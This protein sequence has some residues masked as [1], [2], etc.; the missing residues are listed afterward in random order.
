MAVQIAFKDSADVGFWKKKKVDKIVVGEY[1]H[2]HEEADRY[3][4][5]QLENER[6]TVIEVSLGKSNSSIGGIIIAGWGF[7]SGSTRPRATDE[8]TVNVPIRAVMHLY[9]QSVKTGKIM[10]LTNPDKVKAD[11]TGKKGDFESFDHS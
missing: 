6:S 4:V 3:S 2:M 1:M 5:G 9:N 11:F 10:D 8:F 7:V